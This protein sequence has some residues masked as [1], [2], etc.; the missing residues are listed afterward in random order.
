[1][2][3]LPLSQG[4]VGSVDDELFQYLSQFRWSYR[5]ERNGNQGI[6]TMAAA[7]I[8]AGERKSMNV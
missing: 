2:Q 1:M 7:A 3:S 4:E 5:S 8:L 6:A